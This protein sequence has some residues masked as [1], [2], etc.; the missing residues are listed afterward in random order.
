MNRA[1]FANMQN[2]TV[3][4]LPTY[5]QAITTVNLPNGVKKVRRVKKKKV[6]AKENQEVTK[7]QLPAPKKAP[8]APKY[9]N[10]PLESGAVA[11][12]VSQ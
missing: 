2:G 3:L 11:Q 10:I 7:T 4:S 1:Q 9:A 8:E 12:L 5:Q 6:A